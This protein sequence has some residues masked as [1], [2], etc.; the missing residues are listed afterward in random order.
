M[1]VGAEPK[2]K[3]NAAGLVGT[4]SGLGLEAC[5]ASLALSANLQNA[6]K[7]LDGEQ[8]IYASCEAFC[9]KR[10]HS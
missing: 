10:L 6:R 5:W 4:V 2:A 1:Q 8:R 3:P 9:R 7:P